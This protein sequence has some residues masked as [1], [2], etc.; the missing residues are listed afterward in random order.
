MMRKTG[1]AQAFGPIGSAVAG[2][3]AINFAD[4]HSV[5]HANK[6]RV[7]FGLTRD[8]TMRRVV[9]VFFLP[10]KQIR[11]DVFPDAAGNAASILNVEYAGDVGGM[12][13]PRQVGL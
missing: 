2:A 5:H 11:S 10:G 13:R 3:D 4:P 9:S 8:V 1:G 12:W 7:G 6:L